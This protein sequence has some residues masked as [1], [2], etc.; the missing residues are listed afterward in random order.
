MN[1]PP[2]Y[3]QQPNVP[4]GYGAPGQSY[5]PQGQYSPP[6]GYSAMP[7]SGPYMPPPPPH[8]FRGA[9]R[10]MF[11]PASYRQP[12]TGA[13]GTSSLIISIVSIF[14]CGILSPISLLLGFAG[15]IGKKTHKGA[16]LAGVIISI[17]PA[18]FWIFAMTFGLHHAFNS[19]KYALQATGPVVAAIDE[20]KKD[21]DG[22]VPPSLDSLVEEGYLPARWNAGLDSVDSP[23]KSL[24]EGKEWKEFLQ[25]GP[26]SSYRFA[27]PPRRA[28]KRTGTEIR[29]DWIDDGDDSA[30]PM[31]P[32]T[33]EKT[34]VLKFIGVDG[35]WGNS[36]DRDAVQ[37]PEKKFDL[38]VFGG[39]N[40]SAMREL[41]QTKRQLESAQQEALAKISSLTKNDL[42]KARQRLADNEKELKKLAAKK[43]LQSKAAIKADKDCSVWLKAIG[44]ELQVITAIENK[45]QRLES[46][47]NTIK[48]SLA[49][50]RSQEA[51][52]KLADNKQELAELQALLDNTTKELAKDETSEYLGDDAKSKAADDWLEDQYK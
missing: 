1:V 23:V 13:F 47:L 26:G 10:M 12:G 31:V 20:Y 51:M 42:P 36:D 15:L 22:R 45:M 8:G 38:S 52:A 9:T 33:T 24:V 2:G 28:V 44:Q 39:S 6:Q 7:Q 30:E 43:N 21:H 35:V 17:I 41:A 11:N 4:P 46:S 25:Y 3:N 49:N 37:N 19:D 29:E 32:A 48:G 18:A 5:P 14:L 16:A 34:Y 27:P 50:L 40:T